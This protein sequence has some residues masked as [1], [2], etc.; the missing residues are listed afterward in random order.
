[1]RNVT[2]L[3]IAATA[4]LIGSSAAT[5]APAQGAQLSDTAYMQVARCAGLAASGKVGAS[6]G[7]AFAS[8]V[9]SQ[10]GSRPGYIMDKAD[11]MQRDAKRE[12]SRAGDVERSKLAAEL[13]GVCAALKTSNSS[14]AS[15]GAVKG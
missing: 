12:A 1:M 14:L 8:L 15:T 6:D 11:Q 2:G 9:K 7:S 13:T 5:A 10:A 4:L 3:A